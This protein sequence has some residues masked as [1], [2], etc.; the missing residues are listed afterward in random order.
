LYVNF[1]IFGFKGLTFGM[2]FIEYLN[3]FCMI[4][5]NVKVYHVLAPHVKKMC[6]GFEGYLCFFYII[7]STMN[8]YS[9]LSFFI[10]VENS[11]YGMHS[12]TCQ[13]TYLINSKL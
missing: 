8:F 7:S 10:F 4:H 5:I 6:K 3:M 1:M 2:F 13:N 12:S 11:S 9:L